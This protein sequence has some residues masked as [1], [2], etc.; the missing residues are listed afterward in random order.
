MEKTINEMYLEKMVNSK[1]WMYRLMIASHMDTPAEYLA[2]LSDDD[3]WLVRCEVATNPNTLEKDVIKLTEDE[4]SRV[5][6]VAQIEL[7]RR[8]NQER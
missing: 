2:K 6:E 7:E 5:R 8:R 1:V 3:Y 4:D